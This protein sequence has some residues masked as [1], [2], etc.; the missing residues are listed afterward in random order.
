CTHEGCNKKYGR[1]DQLARHMVDVSYPEALY[2]CQFPGC[3]SDY[4]WSK[5]LTRHQRTHTG[6]RP[7]PCSVANC[8]MAFS[9]PDTLIDHQRTHTG[10]KPF[11]CECG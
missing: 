2:I 6:E 11:A 9:R 5:S 3:G 4:S 10:E 7:Y 1:R 8:G